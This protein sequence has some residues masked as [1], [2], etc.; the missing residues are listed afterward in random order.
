MWKQKRMHAREKSWS[1]FIVVTPALLAVTRDPRS[2]GSYS[3]NFQPSH[4]FRY[5]SVDPFVPFGSRVSEKNLCRENDKFY[6]AL[7]PTPRRILSIPFRSFYSLATF[8]SW[9]YISRKFRAILFLA[10]FEISVSNG[11]SNLPEDLTKSEI[12]FA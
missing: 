4:Q 1:I 3:R 9:V 10:N 2:D 6:Y 12:N 8:A 7:D 5:I 11:S